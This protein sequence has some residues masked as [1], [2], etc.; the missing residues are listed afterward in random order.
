MCPMHQGD[1]T[2]SDCFPSICREH[3]L[4]VGIPAGPA[5]GQKHLSQIHQMDSERERHLQA[6]GLQSGFKAV[7]QTQEQARHELRDHGES[8]QVRATC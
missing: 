2:Q 5:A 3:H 6:G 1:K 8:S 7:G 4:P